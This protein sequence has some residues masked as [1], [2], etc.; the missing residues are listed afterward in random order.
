MGFGFGL[1]WRGGGAAVSF[2]GCRG[3]CAGRA[4]PDRF[5]APLSFPHSP[6]I[7]RTTDDLTWLIAETSSLENLRN[8]VPGPSLW[9][10]GARGARGGSRCSVSVRS[11]ALERGLSL[12]ASPLKEDFKVL[13]F[14]GVEA[15]RVIGRGR[16]VCVCEGGCQA[17]PR[18]RKWRRRRRSGGVSVGV[19]ARRPLGTGGRRSSHASAS[20]HTITQ[21]TPHEYLEPLQG[22]IA[23]GARRVADARS[24]RRADTPGEAAKPRARLVHHVGRCCRQRQE[25]SAHRTLIA[26]AG[27][28]ER[29]RRR[30]RRRA[31]PTPGRRRR[32][33]R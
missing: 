17:P 29:N 21:T 4:A 14:C 5:R 28:Q 23:R 19:L 8:M 1:V 10:R 12:C 9:R 20:N 30:S 2:L 24:R 6:R 32:Q 26:A 3:R 27:P 25:E 33:R 15:A 13:M 31:R 7:P 11:K 18:A 22:V 16:S